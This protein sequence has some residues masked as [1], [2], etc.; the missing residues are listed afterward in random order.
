MRIGY[1]Q[2]DPRDNP[3][4]NAQIRATRR[5]V[6]VYSQFLQ[7]LM[8]EYE[9]YAFVV[10]FRELM[11]PHIEKQTDDWAWITYGT[12]NEKGRKP[13]LKVRNGYEWSMFEYLTEPYIDIV[14]LVGY[15]RVF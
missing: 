3:D 10:E 9:T 13:Q 4:K 6:D 2:K 14:P 5:N 15:K 7:L 1:K 12:E 11:N 8:G